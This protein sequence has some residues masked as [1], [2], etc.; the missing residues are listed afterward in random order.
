[1]FNAQYA[2]PLDEAKSLLQPFIAN[3]PISQNINV[4]PWNEVTA[5]ASFSSDAMLCEKG[6]RLSLYTAG[7]KTV[8]VPTWQ[9]VFSRLSQL[10]RR[11][12]QVRDST[13]LAE[14]FPVQAVQAVARNATSYPH[15]DVTTQL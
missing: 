15:R 13:V 1:M 2:G 14:T 11:Y 5:S 12:P 3:H 7:L 10:Y 8:D 4:L 9:T 6:K